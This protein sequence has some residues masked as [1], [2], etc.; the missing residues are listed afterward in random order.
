[1]HRTLDIFNEM[2]VDGIV[3]SSVTYN[4]LIDA[5]A[6]IGKMDLVQMLLENMEK[7]QVKLDHIT[8]CTII[9]GFCVKGDLEKALD[10]FLG[11]QDHNTAGD[12]VIFNTLLDGCC[13]HVRFE[14]ADKLLANMGK[15]AIVPTNFTLTTLVKMWGRR[16]QLDKA[17]EVIDEIPKAFGF[18][19]NSK[20]YSCLISACLSNNQINKAFEVYRMMMQSAHAKPDNRTY[21]SFVSGLCRAGK[22]QEAVEFVNEAF[23]LSGM[24]AVLQDK[25]I[26]VDAMEQLLGLLAQRG[27]TETV[28]M[29]L[30]E[31]MRSAKVPMSAGF[32][33]T[34]LQRAVHQNASQAYQGKGNGKGNRKQQQFLAL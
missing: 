16:K 3:P 24:P 26:E 14:F 23:G 11:M 4:A 5:Q 30:L 12:V 32:Y 21:T 8:Y 20:V 7:D 25:L 13:R 18:Q 29:P 31:R 27:L 1:M 2:R 15:Y 10:V 22:W 28:S 17:F 33:S 19:P 34:G 9:K 6:R